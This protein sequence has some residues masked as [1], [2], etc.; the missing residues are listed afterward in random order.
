LTASRLIQNI[1]AQADSLACVLQY[2]YGPG[3]PSIVQAGTLMRSCRRVLITGMGA[4]MFAAIP[5]KYF[6]CSLG[7]DTV[8]VEAGELL[9]YL[10]EA[11]KDAVV[12]IVSRSG[13]SIEV[14]KLLDVLGSRRK[15]I[16]VTND[17][18]SLLAK[19][20][21]I[22]LH[23]GSLPDEMV[24]IQTYTGTLLAL[25]IL[26]S[27]L[28]DSFEKSKDEIAGYLP[29]L[30][31]L[32][33][34]SLD[35]LQG[36][37]NFLEGQSPVHLLA[38]GPSNSSALEGALLFNEIA[39]HPSVGMP[40]ASFRHGAVELVDRNF[41]GMVFAPKGRT[42][43]LNLALARDLVHFGGQVR[44]IGPSPENDLETGWHEVPATPET[45][46][47]LF[48]IVPVQV[49]ALRLAQLR[50]IVPGTFRY[51]PQVAIDEASFAGS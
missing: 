10:H 39:K 19:K 48:E 21:D 32:I 7:I 12:I 1:K 43:E 37:D 28:D 20:A 9:H 45:V 27:A 30:S 18:A 4:S 17:P 33:S 44:V 6:L 31:R 50:G 41:R 8:V 16:G 15:I 34:A 24:A 14:A 40:I 2:Q 22:S 36:W 23:V 42:R 3:A 47:P 11:Y 35:N 5:L 51:A 29:K 13:E 25:H 49:A 38:R 46:A 26:G